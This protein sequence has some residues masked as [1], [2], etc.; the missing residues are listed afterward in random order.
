M[1]R[2][3]FS[4]NHTSFG[5]G[6]PDA[7]APVDQETAAPPRGR[8]ALRLVAG[9]V[10]SAALVLF[11][12]ATAAFFAQAS[13]PGDRATVIL[14]I[15]AG[16]AIRRT[17][18]ELAP[19]NAEYHLHDPLIV[20]YLNYL[21][22]LVVGDLGTSYQQHRPVFAII[23]E[24]LGATIVLT[25]TAIVFAWIIMV[26]WV[27]LTAGRGPAVRA[28]GS[29]FDT[30]A[31]G[32]PHYWLGI[33]LLL[34]FALSL[35]WFPVIGGTG[36]VGLVLPALTLA[37]P[38]AG[39]L[40]QA[41]RTEFERALDAPFVLSAHMRGMTD[42]GI[43]LRHVLRHAALPGITLSGW[44]LGATI[45]GA[46]VVEAVFARPG[47][48]QVLVTAVSSQD[49]PVVIGIVMLIAAFYVLANLLVDVAYALVDPR[50]RGAS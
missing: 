47:I 50:L 4:E 13:L 7:S 36:A 16:Q 41:T 40:G 42:L 34:V 22:G 45:S 28:V 1:T 27:T 20:Q 48:G 6:E 15:R 14:N 26:V 44:A 10:M 5:E 17:A 8:A 33:I 46:V 31:A 11:G 18:D 38:L 21:K 43:R 23:G 30:V 19:I 24:Q 12:A 37:I 49:M 25:L 3:S 9:R 39:F 32:L 2:T 29:F 35:G